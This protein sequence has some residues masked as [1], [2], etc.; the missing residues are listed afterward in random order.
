MTLLSEKV[1]GSMGPQG[2]QGAAG[3]GGGGGEFAWSTEVSSANPTINTD[4]VQAHS[5]TALAVNITNMSTNLSGTPDNFQR[6]AIRIKD[7]GTA[8]TIAWGTAFVQMGVPLP[9]TTLVNKTMNVL[10]MYDSVPAKWGCIG[11]AIEQ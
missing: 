9:T 11:L 4:E 7:N 8:R 10:F 6:L 5:I 1:R 3:E 2:H